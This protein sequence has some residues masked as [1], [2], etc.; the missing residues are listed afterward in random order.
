MFYTSGADILFVDFKP[1][2]LDYGD[3]Y[4][5]FVQNVFSFYMHS[6]MSLIITYM[7]SKTHGIPVIL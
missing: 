5:E 7:I 6:N 2:L 3:M 1:G 4:F